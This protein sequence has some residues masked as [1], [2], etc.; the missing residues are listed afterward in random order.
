MIVINIIK[1]SNFYK[2]AQ[3]TLPLTA[4]S[5]TGLYL[6]TK[7]NEYLADPVLQRG[8]MHLKRDQR[9]A[10]FCGENINPGWMISREK[11]PGENWIKYTLSVKGQSGKL[12]TTLI[13]DYLSHADL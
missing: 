2:I 4:G 7:R 10:D 3:Y 8:L 9:V 1:M 13:G 11:K 5:A 6:Y 12:K